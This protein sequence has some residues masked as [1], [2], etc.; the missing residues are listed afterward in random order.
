MLS[1]SVK[2]LL[3]S[4]SLEEKVGQMTQLTID[5]ILKDDSNTEV[6]LTKLHSVIVAYDLP[7]WDNILGSIN[8][9][10][11]KTAHKIPL[12]YGIDSIHGAN[13]TQ[14][15]TIFP[16]NIGMAAARNDELLLASAYISAKETRASGI[17]WVFDPVLDVGRQ[18]LWSRF[19]ETFGE[20]S[21][22]CGRMGTVAI[23]GYEGENL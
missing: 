9:F 12:I 3:E 23:S 1:A 17:R 2:S 20:D 13:Y 6:D 21:Y 18:P 11:Q 14:D 10:T 16:H 8:H 22:L 5:V 7:T 19:E 4:L 15:S